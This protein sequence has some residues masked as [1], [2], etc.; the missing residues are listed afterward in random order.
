MG[1]PGT[2]AAPNVSCTFP[3]WFRIHTLALISEVLPNAPQFRDLSFNFNRAL[4]MG[5][6]SSPTS[7]DKLSVH[8]TLCERL[9][10]GRMRLKQGVS[11]LK[12]LSKHVRR[13][14]IIGVKEIQLINYR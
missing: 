7:W 9:I 8:I 1:I 14:V 2:E 6:H 4:S 11:L 10:D 12:Q 13:K 3:T 5:W